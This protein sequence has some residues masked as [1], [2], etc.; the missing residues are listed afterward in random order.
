MP[1]KNSAV[2]SLRIT[3][4]LSISVDCRGFETSA[5]ASI[6]YGIEHQNL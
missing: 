6:L 1:V 4:T 3:R 5:C 2:K